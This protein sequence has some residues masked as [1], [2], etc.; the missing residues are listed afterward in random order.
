M[1]TNWV[2]IASFL[3]PH[4]MLS[5]AL[6]C[7]R[8][9]NK[10]GT[11]TKKRS[12]ADRGEDTRQRTESISLMEVAARTVLQT[13][14]TD[15]EKNALP[16]RGD[17]SWIGIYNEFLKLFRLPLQFDKL[18]GGGFRH[19]SN[20]THSVENTDKTR[21]SSIMGVGYHI[22]AAI[23]SNIMRAGKHS[24][25]FNVNDGN[26]SMNYGITCGIMRPT[27]NDIRS[28]N[29]CH[30][31]I[32]DLSRFSLKEYE[33]LYRNNVDCCL[34]STNMGFGVLRPRWKRWGKSE[35]I[36]MDEEQRLQKKR[37]NENQ[38]FSWE[39]QEQIRE[40][41]FKIGCVL[42]LNEGTLDVFKN[43]RRLG[44]MMSGL[45]GEYCWIVTRPTG[46]GAELSVSIGR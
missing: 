11:D 17:E 6:T 18:A 15:D 30:P 36:V 44:T 37:Q 3:Q 8:F 19:I 45:V 39:G 22:S 23:C 28:L 33:T 24:V 29:S 35:L 13:K 9:G 43:G 5:L 42:D 12:A 34:F 1:E 4:D 20:S 16:R 14:W 26:P 7:K 31:L 32:D 25:S 21:V 2:A 27:T 38:S 41:S 40:T 46:G 10:H